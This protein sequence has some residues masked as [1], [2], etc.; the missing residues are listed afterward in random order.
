[1]RHHEAVV[2]ATDLKDRIKMHLDKGY[3][4]QQ[5]GLGLETYAEAIRFNAVA[6]DILTTHKKNTVS[7]EQFG[8]SDINERIVSLESFLGDIARFLRLTKPKSNGPNAKKEIEEREEYEPMI[9]N[10]KW[11]A[12][13]ATV[14]IDNYKEKEGT[15]ELGKQ[16]GPYFAGDP[17]RFVKDFKADTDAYYALTRTV[18]AGL[19]PVLTHMYTFSKGAEKFI[20]DADRVDEFIA[21]IKPMVAKEPKPYRDTFKAPSH[22]FLAIGKPDEWFESVSGA[23]EFD[24]E[25]KAVTVNYPTK[26]DLV[27]LQGLAVR[28]ATISMGIEQ[29]TYD[30]PT[31]LD[32]TDPPFRGYSNNAEVDEAVSKSTMFEP[33]FEDMHTGIILKLDNAIGNAAH[34][35][36]QY[37]KKALA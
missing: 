2:L 9:Q 16:T 7:I 36:I 4:L 24:Y 32:Y 31:G 20:G 5:K 6:D 1:M 18:E 13:T 26:K 35:L 3:A 10:F 22:T 14:L 15:F 37:M 33:L 29:L 25:K 28:L 19:K 27:A 12:T 8:E 23:P 21:F 30:T 11:L 34:A 17:Q